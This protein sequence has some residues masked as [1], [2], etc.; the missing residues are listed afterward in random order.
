MIGRTTVHGSG[1][2]L[3]LGIAPTRLVLSCSRCRDPLRIPVGYQGDRNVHCVVAMELR[4]TKFGSHELGSDGFR[5]AP[6]YYGRGRVFEAVYFDK[7][8]L[9]YDRGA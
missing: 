8:R 3:Q 6:P 7:D 5:L 2:A 9:S 1:G 4:A